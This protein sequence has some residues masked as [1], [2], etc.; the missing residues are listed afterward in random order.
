MKR[1]IINITV[2]VFFCL[3]GLAQPTSV[4][5]A[6]ELYISGNYQ[7]AAKQYE[8]IIAK[9]G[10]APEL[11][12]NL[13]NAYYKANEIGR[14]ILNYER[15]LRLSPTYDD[16]RFNLEMVHLK[17]VDNIVQVPT[18]FVGRWI[19]NLIKLLTTNQWIVIS[20]MGFV[21]SLSLLFLF[22]FGST[23]HIRKI[24]FYVGSVLFGISFIT[25]IFAGVRKDQLLNH[26]DAIIMS[27]VVTVKS[28]P[29]KSGTDLFQL[30]EGTK[31]N[32]K[33]TL[34]NWSEI[35]LGNGNIGWIENPNIERI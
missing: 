32:I 34:G 16:A 20:V 30:H 28:S 22:V 11:Y 7:D 2:I 8:T 14:S 29:D 15:A 21:L 10:I 25:L 19:E 17:V 5:Q 35:T 18:F 33:S 24:S 4:K 6:N 23:R 12:Y 31:V 13:G 27:G 1:I 9:E 26:N 3:S